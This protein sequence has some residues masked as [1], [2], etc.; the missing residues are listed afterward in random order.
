MKSLDELR[1]ESNEELIKMLEKYHNYVFVEFFRHVIIDSKE[2]DVVAYFKTPR[3]ELM[4]SFGFELKENNIYKAL[5]QAFDRSSF[6]NHFYVVMDLS[7]VTFFRYLS[8]YEFKEIKEHK[9][10]IILRNQI[11][12][13][14]I[15]KKAVWPIQTSLPHDSTNE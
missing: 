10:G 3:K 8:P 12:I 9:I 11:V 5:L 13:P 14:S 15:F 2:V 6:F 4:R 1:E 7:P